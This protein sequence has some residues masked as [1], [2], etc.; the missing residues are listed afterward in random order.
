M[1][2]RPLAALLPAALV[3]AALLPAAAVSAGL[4]TGP[5]TSPASQDPVHGEYGLR[6]TIDDDQIRVGWLVD[7]V[8]PGVL[9]VYRRDERLHRFETEPAQ[10][11]EVRFAMPDR[12][13]IVLR[14]GALESR[15]AEREPHGKPERPL[16][17]TT[18]YLDRTAAPP[19]AALTDVDSL[20]VVGDVHGQYETLVRL[21]RN[22]GLVD[23]EGAWTG[24]RK[25]VVFLGDIFDRGPDV[26]RALWFLYRLER[27]AARA[28]GGAHV[29]LGNHEIMVFTGDLR[30]VSPRERRLAV[31]HDTTYPALFDIRRSVLGRWLA[32]R[33][34]L[35]KVDRV[36]LA[37]G[38]VA[39][40]YA[41]YQVEEFNDSLRSFLAEDFFYYLG[42]IFDPTDS[43]AALVL[44]PDM[45]R[46]VHGVEHLVV[47]D[48]ATARRR[49]D[50]FE[51]DNSV[52]WFR[53]YLRTD[54]LQPILQ[55]VLDSYDADIHVVAHTPV[56]RIQARMGGRMIAVD[57]A[58]PATQMLLLV[59]EKHGGYTPLLYGLHGPPEPVPLM[60]PP[61]APRT[62][63]H[64]GT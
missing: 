33:P 61:T 16:H 46:R 56:P 18:L 38:G 63:P 60:A 29:V 19:P 53:E 31:L 8:A 54:A 13:T 35:M 9:E 3:S 32:S 57:A 44:D 39:P 27:E 11:H 42:P 28:G 45:A 17:S 30:Y 12:G 20:F 48:S 59:R 62:P 41:D 5:W 43:T 64:P 7:G 4:G 50:F 55:E 15:S 37:H 2:A 24:G 36:L 6:V 51:S 23:P 47:M 22:G 34:G 25:H 58:Q 26:T 14:Y 40:A 21:L 1:S 10:A 49:L 52:F